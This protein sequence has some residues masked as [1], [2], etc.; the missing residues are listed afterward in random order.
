MV[1]ILLKKLKMENVRTVNE[2]GVTWYC[3]TDYGKSLGYT[4]PKKMFKKIPK[5]KFRYF[6]TDKNRLAKYTTLDVLYTRTG[7]CDRNG[8][9]FVYA[10]VIRW[11]PDPEHKIVKVGRT[12][13]WNTRCRAYRL[14][15]APDPILFVK[16]VKY[17]TE[18]ENA[19]LHYMNTRYAVIDGKEFFSVP[20]NV[21]NETLKT[22]LLSLL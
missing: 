19:M 13:N 11:K 12:T 5:D 15:N 8:N 20:R 17:Q 22:E 3:V 7:Q 6:M 1:R 16:K 9:G 2:N 21:K 4:E 10:F 18:A 14:G